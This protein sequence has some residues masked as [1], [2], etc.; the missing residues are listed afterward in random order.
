MAD[1]KTIITLNQDELRRSVPLK[2]ALTAALSDLSSRE[3]D[4]LQRRSG[5]STGKT[6]TLAE[7]GEA[8]GVTR[9]RVRQIEAAA[10][11]KLAQAATQPPLSAITALA[12]AELRE[13][14]G[15][16]ARSVLENEFLPKAQQG[17]IGNASLSLLLELIPDIRRVP[18]SKQIR[19]CYTL[20]ASHEQALTDTVKAAGAVLKEAKRPL[21]IDELSGRLT[22]DQVG[23]FGHLLNDALLESALQAGTQFVPVGERWGLASWRDINPKNIRDKTLYML[24]QVETPLHFTEIAERIRGAKFDHKR[25]TDQAVHNELI[26]GD[27]FVLIGRGIYALKDWGYIEGTVADVIA[28]VLEKADGPLEREA[29]VEAVLAQR[30]V[31]RNTILINLQDA[32]FRHDADKR[33]RLTAME[34]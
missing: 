3:A 7:I 23:D 32:R 10:R 20:S 5:L 12:V 19:T 33:Y 21:T 13:R 25:V 18:E 11:V 27:E 28:D 31:S 24:K 8:L 6:E 30:Q 29:I 9:E 16:V 2:E 22:S 14:G 34:G 17:P 15:I 4:V 1:L 26:N